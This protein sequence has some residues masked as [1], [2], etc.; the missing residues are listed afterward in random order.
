MNFSD[1]FFAAMTPAMNRA[2]DA[3]ENL[4]AGAIANPDENRMVGHYWL[5]TPE[6]APNPQITQAILDMQAKVK[7]F[8]SLVHSGAIKTPRGEKFEDLLVIGI[9]GSALGPQ[10]AADALGSSH[11][12]MRVFFLDNTDPDGIDRTLGR[13]GSALG[14]T[15]SLVISKS[16]GTPETRNGMIETAHTY[17]RAGLQF[18]KHAVAITG[19]GSELARRAESEKWLAIFPMWDWVGGRTSEL[20]AV[21]LLPAALQGINIDEI[22]RG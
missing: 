3:M 2:F 15:L 14:R 8:A 1:S 7:S 6:R 18:A 17:A 22:L 4:E 13:I 12:K 9:G 5:R 11:D 19:E 10:L 20:S 16:G 21:G